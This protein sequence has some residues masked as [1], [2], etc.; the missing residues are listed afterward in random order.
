MI[1]GAQISVYAWRMRATEFRKNLVQTLEKASKGASVII[2]YKGVSLRLEVVG[3]KSKLA[4]AVRRK[5]I[6]G[7]PDLLAGRD[8]DLRE[9]LAAKWALED[10]QL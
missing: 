8:S 3:G 1:H 4:G 7:D 6:V 10:A 2:E 9:G 5:A